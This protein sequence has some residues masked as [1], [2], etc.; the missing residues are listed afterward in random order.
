MIGHDQFI[1]SV[2]D[3]D[4]VLRSHMQILDKFWPDHLPPGSG[5]IPNKVSIV[6]LFDA[7]RLRLNQIAEKN[8]TR[9]DS[10]FEKAAKRI[11]GHSS[12]A[13]PKPPL[14][15]DPT[16]KTA[17]QIAHEEARARMRR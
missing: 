13:A 15:D 4:N 16:A 14:H 5:E 17:M 12:V 3:V 7:I 2:Q 10:P 11:K 8:A 1:L 9:M 6:E